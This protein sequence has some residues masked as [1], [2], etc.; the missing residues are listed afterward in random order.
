MNVGQEQEGEKRRH[1]GPKKEKIAVDLSTHL[2]KISKL[3]FNIENQ[4]RGSQTWNFPF[5][6]RGGH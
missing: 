5:F 6:L 3:L 1:R 2:L 4:K